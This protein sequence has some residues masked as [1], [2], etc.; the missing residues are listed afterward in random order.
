[1]QISITFVPP[2]PFAPVLASVYGIGTPMNERDA[3]RSN[4]RRGVC[5]VLAA[6]SGAGKS[7]I[8]RALVEGE[9]DLSLSVSVTT[10]PPREGE[11]DGVDY[12]FLSQPQFDAMAEAGALLEWA[13]VFGRSYG[14]PRRPIE[15]R[16]A[17]GQDVALDIDWQGW[18]QLRAAL[19][20]DS[21]GVFLSPPSLS[22][23]DGRLRGRGS[24]AAEEVERRMLAAR[25]EMSHWHEFDYLVVNDDFGTCVDE[26]KAI[27]R[28][29]RCTTR[30]KLGLVRLITR[31]VQQGPG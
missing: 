7:S 1:M 8:L 2:I 4:E 31:M 3:D 9:H 19:P 29:V 16:L 17:A 14:T 13:T 18:R 30:R 12:T 21:A 6:P 24:D 27:L 25:Q 23:L 26:V 5:L 28:A 20:D 22:A 15:E 10:R 11:R